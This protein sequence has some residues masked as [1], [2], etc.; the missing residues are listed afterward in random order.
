VEVRRLTAAIS[1][2][3]GRRCNIVSKEYR[4][5]YFRHRPTKDVERQN[6]GHE[7][8]EY[9]ELVVQHQIPKRT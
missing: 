1:S 2:A 6:N 5:D 3:K 9:V 7:E 8:E 4:A